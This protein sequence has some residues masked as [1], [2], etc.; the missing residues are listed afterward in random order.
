MERPSGLLEVAFQIEKYFLSCLIICMTLIVFLGVLTRYMLGFSFSW[1]EE[2][3]RYCL[4]WVTFL[5]AAALMKG[6]VNHPRVVMLVSALPK[7]LQKYILLGENIVMMLVLGVIVAGAIIIM[8][9]HSREVSPAME[10]PMNIIYFAIP[11]SA[12]ISLIRLT[13]DI[14]RL[15]KTGEEGFAATADKYL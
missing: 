9:V 4:V 13:L 2:L 7:S 14:W 3:P 1:I 15:L 11:L 10:I 8:R 6:G 5:G 12:S